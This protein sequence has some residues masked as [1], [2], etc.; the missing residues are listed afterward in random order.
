MT[1]KSTSGFVL[2][3]GASLVAS[4]VLFGGGVVVSSVV[5]RTHPPR[6]T[7]DALGIRANPSPDEPLQS[8]KGSCNDTYGVALFVRQ[9]DNSPDKAKI[10]GVGAIRCVSKRWQI[11][12]VRLIAQGQTLLELRSVPAEWI[13]AVNR[14]QETP[15]NRLQSA[16][17]KPLASIQI[18]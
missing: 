18:S 5:H 4:V 9:N 7:I 13:E 6:G 16:P 12:G 14:L 17:G 11:D 3:V 15:D 10:F 1:V 2:N 8:I